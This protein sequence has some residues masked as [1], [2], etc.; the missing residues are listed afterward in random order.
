[1]HGTSN[2]TC[3]LNT[4][5]M[6]RASFEEKILSL[7]GCLRLACFQEKYLHKNLYDRFTNIYCCYLSTLF[8]SKTTT[9][10]AICA[11]FDAVGI[12]NQLDSE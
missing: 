8:L 3:R 4:N 2:S 1:M 10:E 6:A 9:N 11:K 12:H 7:K 5:I